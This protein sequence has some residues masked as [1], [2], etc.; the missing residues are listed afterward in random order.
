MREWHG[1]TN[2]TMWTIGIWGKLLYDTRNQLCDDL[3]GEV[4]GG[5]KVHEGGDIRILIAALYKIT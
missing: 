2:T 5:R 3:G 1:Q 4:G